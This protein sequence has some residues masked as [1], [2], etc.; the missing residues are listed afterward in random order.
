MSESKLELAV[1]GRTYAVPQPPAR[2][3][4]ALQASWVVAHA[5]RAGATLPPYA[6]ERM[7]RYDTGAADIDEDA[8]GPVWEQMVS[9]DVGIQDLRRAALAAYVWICTGS[10]DAAHKILDPDTEGTDSGPKA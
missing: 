4:L 5:R 3:G 10:E 2:I 8:L 1:A 7:E 6:L 9:D